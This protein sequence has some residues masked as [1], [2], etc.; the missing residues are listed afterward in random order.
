MRTRF[1][2]QFRAPAALGIAAL[3]VVAACYSGSLASALPTESSSPTRS[4]APEASGSATPEPLHLCGSADLFIDYAPYTTVTLAGYG[5]DF[6]VA[7]VVSFEPAIFNTP[8]GKAPPD[9]LK[10]PSSLQP[11]PN[12]AT[13]IY[14]P[15][16]VVIDDVVSGAWSAGPR[17]FL[18]E[19][20]TVPIED[21]TV[22]CF[23]MRVDA[24]PRVEPGSRYVLIVSEALDSEGQEALLLSKARFA[25][26]VDSKG[27][28]TTVDGPMS[29]DKL[30]EV[31]MGAAAS[32][33]PKATITGN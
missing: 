19:G 20:G 30:T 6:V 14:T 17:Q 21:G 27:I 32:P 4:S 25:W 33:D 2:L 15:I 9:F 22:D 3:F 5:W 16:N 23:T 8:D 13:L 12:A 7:D 10:P 11:N 28:A 31:V 1:C 26:P 24:A 18:I 29:I